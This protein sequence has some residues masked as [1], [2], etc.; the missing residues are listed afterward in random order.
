MPAPFSARE[1]SAPGTWFSDPRSPSRRLHLSWHGEQNLVVISLWSEDRCTGSFRLPVSD[2]ARLAGAIVDM[3]GR[4]LLRPARPVTG[5]AP[6]RGWRGLLIRL[7]H[8]GAP[9]RSDVIHLVRHT[10]ADS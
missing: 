7:A 6:T 5:P 4:A 3:M 9:A 8:A 1:P 10:A 2:A